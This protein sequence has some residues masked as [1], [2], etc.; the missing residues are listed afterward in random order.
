VNITKKFSVLILAAGAGIRMK[1][2]IPKVMHKLCGKSLINWAVEAAFALRPDNVIVVLGYGS[3]II[4]KSLS[5][6]NIKFVY[7][8]EQLGSAHA[9]MQAE[10]ILG[11]YDGD[12]LVIS[13]DVPLVKSSTLFSLLKNNENTGSSVT[14]LTAEIENPF[15]YGRIIRKGEGLEKIVEEKDASFSEKKIKEV[16]SGIYCFDKNLWKILS[17]VKPNNREKEYYITDTI[18]ILKKL[19]KKTSAFITKNNYEIMGVNNRFD[20]LEVE[21][22]LNNIKIKKLL[23]S[24]VSLIGKSNLYISYDAKIGCDTVIYPGVFIDVGVSIGK[25]CLIKG[26]SYI[27]NSKI[28]DGSIISYS[29][30]EGAVLYKMVEV[31]GFSCIRQ[32]SILEDNVK[33]GNFSEI[34]NSKISKNTKINHF[35]YIGDAQIGENVNIGAGTVTCN[36]D[37]VKKHQTIIGSKSF[38]GSNVTIIAPIKVGHDTFIAAGSTITR[39]VPS[40]KFVIAR[41]KQELK[42][43]KNNKLVI[44]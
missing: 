28:G 6:K 26:T 41:A 12:I 8:K 27:I 29:S 42:H 20:L 25:N 17:K 37:G 1:S 44:S 39:D 33:I 36:Y 13:G 21:N 15:G 43:K 2:S 38:V 23:D 4:E 24:G 3:D 10:E 7:Q 16:N 14:V 22:V 5:G 31:G 30:V 11:G 32:N 34:K 40:G 18:A 9:V 19:G 35:S